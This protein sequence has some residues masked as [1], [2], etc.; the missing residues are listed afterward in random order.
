[1]PEI[2]NITR[3]TEIPLIGVLPFGVVARSDNNLIQVRPTSICNLKCRFCSTGA[4]NFKLH[5]INYN[6]ELDYLLDYVNEII[7]FKDIETMIF[8]DSVGE[9]LAYPKFVEL[10]KGLNKIKNVKE[11]SVVTNGTLLNKEKIKALEKAGLNRINLSL[12]SLNKDLARNLSGKDSYN[13]DKIIEIAKTIASSKIELWLTPIYIP[14]LN[15]DSIEQLIEFSKEI[16]VEIRI[17][18]YEMHKYGRKMKV[19][20]QNYYQFYKKLEEWEKKY[21]IK[22]F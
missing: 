11:I 1:M 19:K 15:E 10:I 18:K 2:I 3:E 13:V 8:I 14:K 20:K 6:V 9:P 5:P 22:L 16:G 12:H 4:N 17:Q 21:D 7:K